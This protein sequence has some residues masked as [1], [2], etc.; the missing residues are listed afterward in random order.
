MKTPMRRLSK[1]LSCI[2][3][4]MGAALSLGVKPLRCPC[5]LARH[6]VIRLTA[7]GITLDVVANLKLENASELDTL[8][9]QVTQVAN[10]AYRGKGTDE[11]ESWTTERHLIDGIRITEAAARDML[12]AAGASNDSKDSMLLAR[13]PGDSGAPPR[14]VG[15]VRIEYSDT[16]DEAEIGFFSVDPDLQGKGIGG[17]LIRAAERHA[18]SESNA[19][20]LVLWVISIREDLLSWYERLGYQRTEASAPFPSASANVGTPRRPDLEFCRLEKLLPPRGAGD[21]GE[22]KGR[23]KP[24]ARPATKPTANAPTARERSRVS[25]LFRPDTLGR[26]SSLDGGGTEGTRW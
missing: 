25:D 6:G 4:G 8:A 18:A 20:R 17:T 14:V 23:R 19:Q 22:S 5:G 1:I 16:G 7:S 24:A 13:M 21:G 15:T 11:D 2:M 9:L 10:W 3:M 12:Q 26:G